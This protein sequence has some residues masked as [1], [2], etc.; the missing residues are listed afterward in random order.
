MMID[1]QWIV[2]GGVAALGG[3]A[4]LISRA[5]E[6]KRRAAYEEFSL[7]RGFT[8]EAE[9]PDAERRFEE[10]FE[11]F[12]QGRRRKWGYTIGGS[13]NGVPFIAFEYSWVTGSGKNS[14]THRL[15][16]I[17]WERDGGTLPKFALS[18][19]G[20]F[21]RLG[22]MF[23]MQDIDFPESSDFSQ[24]YRLKGPDEAGIRALFTP[25][26]RQFFA[27]TP[28]QYVAG[29]GRFLFWWRNARLPLAEELDEWLEQGDHVRRRFLTR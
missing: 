13:K 25:E 9:R 1:I 15:S 22:G 28:E 16:G 8:F 27:S 10:V 18:P 12:T 19:E 20:W 24:A 14:S 5:Q 2:I 6:R 21:S 26:I 7:I 23:G 11:P 17:V 3:A 4:I 29:G